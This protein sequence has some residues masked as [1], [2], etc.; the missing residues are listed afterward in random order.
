MS[1]KITALVAFAIFLL[2]LSSCT[3][4][5]TELGLMGKWKGSYQFT[6]TFTLPEGQPVTITTTVTQ[7]WEFKNDDTYTLQSTTSSSS[8]DGMNSSETINETGTIVKA[9]IKDKKITFKEDK[10][11]TEMFLYYTLAGNKLTL[12]R[13]AMKIELIKQ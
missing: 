12:R 3:I 1:K 4:A 5:G 11:G 13:D 6:N 9:E 10:S 8:S 2:S 7:E